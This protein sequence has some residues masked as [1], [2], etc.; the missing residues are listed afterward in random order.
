QAELEPATSRS[1]RPEGGLLELSGVSKSWDSRRPPVVESI[2]LTLVPGTLLS[3]T[4]GNGAG[5]TTLLR[6]VAGLI[7]ADSG[8]VRL[9]GFDPF[10]ERREFP[11]RLGVLSAGQS[12]LDAR[13]TVEAHLDY[14]GRLA[15]LPRPD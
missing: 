5:K 7:G 9:D 1:E 11:R 3:L 15:L 13:V 10:R 12:G 2:D 6:I 4:G 8:S 14:W